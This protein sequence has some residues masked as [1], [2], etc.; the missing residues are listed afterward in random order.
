M[1]FRLYIFRT[2]F[3]TPAHKTSAHTVVR[4]ISSIGVMLR[5]ASAVR[6]RASGPCPLL[7]RR[8]LSRRPR[9]AR[10]PGPPPRRSLAGHRH[11]LVEAYPP[12]IAVASALR[13]ADRLVERRLTFPQLEREPDVPERGFA[14]SSRSLHLS[15]SLL[16]SLWATIQPIAEVERKGSVP[17]LVRRGRAPAASLVW[18]VA[19]APNP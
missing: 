13:A 17:M 14:H 9:T 11:Q 10:G 7:P 5:A 12:E 3:Y 19:R 15:Y 2:K 6:R 8:A 16:A 4:S 18:R 1:Y